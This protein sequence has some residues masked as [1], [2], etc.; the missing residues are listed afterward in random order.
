MCVCV[1]TIE[2]KRDAYALRVLYMY[3]FISTILLE[4]KNFIA[5]II[6]YA[7][8]GYLFAFIFHNYFY[9]WFYK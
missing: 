1:R 8:S 9:N 7:Q 4:L 2:S 5:K 6:F 3:E